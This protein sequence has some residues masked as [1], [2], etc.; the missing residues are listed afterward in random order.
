MTE[1]AETFWNGKNVLVTGGDGFVASN[2]AARLITRGANVVATVRHFRPVSTIRFLPV[3]PDE[4]PDIELSDLS[5]FLSVQRLCNRHQID[6]IFHLAASA[7]VSDA[8]KSPVSTFQNNV[9]STLNILETARINAIPRV[10]VASSDKSYGD[11]AGVGDPE[12]LPY[13]E[14]HALRGLDVYSASKVCADMMS[15]TYAYQFR[16]PVLV[17]R[18]CNIYGP[19]DLNFTR[20]IPRTVLRLFA[21]L[22]PVINQG[23]ENVLRE[24]VYVDDIVSAYELLAQHV[25]TQYRAAIPNIGRKPYGWAA[26]NVGSYA[27]ESSFRPES[28]ANIKS[29]KGL[30]AQICMAMGRPEVQPKVISKD[31]NF[32][33]I[34]DQYLDASKIRKLGFVAHTEL[35]EGLE[36]TIEWYRHHQKHFMRI[37]H[38][39]L[40]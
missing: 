6:T 33:E 20:L 34:P 35:P 9:V 24:Y 19:G 18:S 27:P 21:G 30:I 26:Y 8:S 36:R 25:A 10:I 13:N 37:G 17:V 5:D 40:Q 15:Q 38:N 7:I 1:D 12:G 14:N 32:I 16:L 3:R 28:C 39:Y 4:M 2:L 29:V 11:H 22:V 31:V 23:N